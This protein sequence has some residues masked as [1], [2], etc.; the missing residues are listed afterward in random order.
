MSK[1]QIIIFTRNPEL[2]KVKTRLAKV[3]GDIDALKIYTFLLNKTKEVTLKLP[4]DKAVYY[5]E[6]IQEHD[7]WNPQFY[8]KYR[9][10]GDDLGDRMENAFKDS[11]KKGY[12]KA[13]FKI[14]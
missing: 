9:Q 7:I 2:G 5:S 8:Q 1:N 4:C 11:F 10:K 13:W 6:K 14:S 3:I 12:E